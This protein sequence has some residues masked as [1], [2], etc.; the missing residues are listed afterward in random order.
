[1]SVCVPSCPY[2]WRHVRYF[3]S[4]PC[5]KNILILHRILRYIRSLSEEDVTVG[6]EKCIQNLSNNVRGE[7]GGSCGNLD[8]NGRIQIN[9]SSTNRVWRCGMD[10]PCLRIGSN[11]GLL[12]TRL[13][14]LKERDD[15]GYP[16]L[17]K[18]TVLKLILKETGCEKVGWIKS[19]QIRT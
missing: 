16:W 9:A 10:L 19:A 5:F 6:H 17:S 15:L 2:I 18:R 4:V 3:L 1:M 7:G 12:R 14:T 13:G 11:S 8:V